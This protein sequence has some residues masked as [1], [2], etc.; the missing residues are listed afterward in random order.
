[1]ASGVNPRLIVPVLA[2]LSLAACAAP[3]RYPSLAI[4]DAERP[5]GTLQPTEA[6]PYVPPATPSET[7]DRLGR[8]TAEAQAAHQTFLAA[9]ERARA[10]VAAGR[11]TAEGSDAWSKAQIA[12]ADLEASRSQAMIAL[13]DLDRLY[14]EAELEAAD[15]T[16]ITAARDEVSALVD[17]ENRTIAELQGS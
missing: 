1:M 12:L 13:A 17:S 4:R 14:L 5:S 9:T 15:M 2:L 16:R 6:E 7:L 8:L 10:P 11:G 3:S